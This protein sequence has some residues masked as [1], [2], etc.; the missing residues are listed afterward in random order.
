MEENHLVSAERRK[1]MSTE[2]LVSVV[3]RKTTTTENLASA[4]RREIMWTENQVSAVWEKT[5]TA[6]NLASVEGGKL[7]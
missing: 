6:D 4:G 3:W 2:I 5:T 1:I 7:R